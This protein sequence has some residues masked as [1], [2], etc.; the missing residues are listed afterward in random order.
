MLDDDFIHDHC[1]DKPAGSAKL[2]KKSSEFNDKEAFVLYV[3]E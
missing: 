2:S 1:Y 3:Y